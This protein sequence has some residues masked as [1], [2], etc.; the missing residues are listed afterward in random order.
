MKCIRPVL[1]VVLAVHAGVLLAEPLPPPAIALEVQGELKELQPSIPGSDLQQIS[2]QL[3]AG[4]QL[5]LISSAAFVPAPLPGFGS[6]Y[7]GVDIVTIEAGRQ[8]L[9]DGRQPLPAGQWSGLRNRFA[10]VMIRADQPLEVQ[11]V[12]AANGAQ[13]LI[14]HGAEGQY[15]LEI[16]L[17]P[18][19]YRQLRAADG[20][21][22]ALLFA[23]IWS[24]LRWLSIGLLLLWEALYQLIGNAGLAI[25]LLSLAVKLLMTPLTRLAERWQGEVNRIHGLLQPE[26]DQIR[27]QYRG[28]EAHRL[29]L[30]VYARHGI[31]PWFSIRS[32]AGFLI[33]IPVFIAAFHMLAGNIALAEESFLWIADLAR[34]DEWLRLPLTLPFFGAWLNLLPCLMTMLTL[35]SAWLLHEPALGVRQRHRQRRNLALL[36][37]AFFLLFYTFP[38]AMVLYWTA[39]NFWHLVKMLIERLLSRYQA[40]VAGHD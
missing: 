17:G 16:Y 39:N 3:S 38:A 2:V 6:I 29:T 11:P 7:A 32:L 36:A 30:A 23:G 15:E 40:A 9:L 22:G 34:P 10:A 31:S 19:E 33:Q 12:Y 4:G 13:E 27:Q 35:L 8:R 20:A 18:V 25:V 24:W 26:L 1:L 28:E 37:L 14:L 5:R 21:L